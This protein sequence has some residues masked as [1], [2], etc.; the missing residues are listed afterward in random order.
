MTLINAA[1]SPTYTP[2]NTITTTTAF[3]IARR[4]V[5]VRECRSVGEINDVVT[6]AVG[7]LVNDDDLT[8]I[9]E[10]LSESCHGCGCF[11]CGCDL[12]TA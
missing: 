3:V 9:V 10:T 5:V 6:D 12:S 4:A 8:M 7:L 1:A 2:V 11:V